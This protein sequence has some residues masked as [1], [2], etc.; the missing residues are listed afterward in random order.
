MSR[1]TTISSLLT[2]ANVF[3]ISIA[4]LSPSLS[5]VAVIDTSKKFQTIE[6]FG[7]GFVFGTYPYGRVSKDELYDSLFNKAGVSI[8]RIGNRYDPEKNNNVDEIP[9]IRE[10]RQKWPSVKIILTSWS[11]PA[12]LKSNNSTVGL[13][14]Q[15][16]ATIKKVDSIYAYDAYGDYWLKSA[17]HFQD[18]GVAIHWI[19][20][21][22]EPNWAPLY[23]GCVFMPTESPAFASYGKALAAVYAKISAMPNPIPLIGPDILGI[24]GNLLQAYMTSPDMHAEQLAAICHH[25]YNGAD[26]ISMH[27][28]A[29]SFPSALLYQTEYLINEGGAG[30]TW[31]DHAQTIQQSLVTEGVS[32]YDVFALTYRQNSTHCLFSLDSTGGGYK[33]RPVYYAFKHFSK[34]IH[35]GWRRVDAAADEPGVKISAFMAPSGDSLA[36]VAINNNSTAV[37][38]FLSL[39][40]SGAQ[41]VAVYRT[42]ETKKYAFEGK[43]SGSDAI[44]LEPRSITT[45]ET[46]PQTAS[47]NSIV[48][49]SPSIKSP[50]L[51]K[52]ITRR[53]G[54]LYVSLSLL[55]NLPHTLSVFDASGKKIRFVAWQK[56]TDHRGSVTHIF[57]GPFANGIYFLK[58]ECPGSVE[59]RYIG[60]GRSD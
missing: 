47:M 18:S 35:R 3:F 17:G 45:L 31:F 29:A 15:D 46:P 8:V 9:M 5:A 33:A 21:Q 34:S 7:G 16:T 42:T 10:I 26:S 6:G 2:A 12:Y 44:T 52:T 58:L 55:F 23:D 37:S 40:V 30:L 36:V 38:F 22:N 50:R 25:F 28:V 53:A 27:S 56:A 49:N 24:G 48:K 32:M 19:S 14:G 1:L 39:P 43:I 57:K 4:A 59:T 20:I 54:E 11:P 60:M 51:I 41:E 13:K